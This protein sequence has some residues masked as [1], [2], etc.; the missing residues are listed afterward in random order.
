M[1]VSIKKKKSETH[2]I[3]NIVIDITKNT[4]DT[5][6]TVDTIDTADTTHNLS[7]LDILVLNNGWNGKNEKLIV[8]IGY[9]CGIYKQL[10][11]ES[12]RYYKRL[13]KGI[14]LSLL[15]LTVFL[16][17]DSI[18][19]LLKGDILI[20]IQKVILFIVAII[21]I[22]NNF[23]KFSETSEQHLYA[24][25]SFNIIYNE[26]RNTMCVYKKDRIN[27]I[28]YM[29]QTIKEYDHLEISSPE[30]P[31]RFIKRMEK[32]IKT[33]DIYKDISMP[34]NQ[35]RK[36]D[37][38]VDKTDGDSD[39]NNNCINTQ[40]TNG[41]SENKDKMLNKF[42]INNMQNIEQ[43]HDCFKIDGEL[44]E[45]DNITIID[46]EEYRRNTLDLHAQYEFNRF[47]TH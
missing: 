21:S 6:D 27:A 8:G 2:N 31:K 46:I 32:R 20:I 17:T 16:T 19:N 7:K 11:E 9:N 13:N 14:N 25:N 22:V 33:D 1:N 12:S 15:I 35:F 29:Q 28:R 24:A 40:N 3:P 44:S 41:I 30:I 4:V 38:I 47:I 36:I 10:H 45:N 23:L 18:I 26:I 5:V 42:K 37:V 34:V 43:I 39:N